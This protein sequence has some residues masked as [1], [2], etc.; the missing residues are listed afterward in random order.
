MTIIELLDRLIAGQPVTPEEAQ[1]AKASL[2]S[3]TDVAA[4]ID[5]DGDRLRT[6]AKRLRRLR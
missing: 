6:A 3:V 2:G 4:G 5:R 1:A